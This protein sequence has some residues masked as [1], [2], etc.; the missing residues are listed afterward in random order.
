MDNKDFEEVEDIFG[1][2]IE[3][4]Y[5]VPVYEVQP[6]NNEI[7]NSVN[8]QDVPADTVNDDVPV[9]ES[10]QSFEPTEHA[11]NIVEP[12]VNE[13]VQTPVFENSIVSE[14]K[15]IDEETIKTDTYDIQPEVTP[16]SVFE[17]NTEVNNYE[18]K[19]EVVPVEPEPIYE[20]ALTDTNEVN[21]GP[22]ELEPTYDEEVN[23][24]PDAIVT[25][26]NKEEEEQENVKVEDIPN[27]KLSDN[28]SLKFV[29]IIGV[30]I[31]IAIML[32]PLLNK[33]SI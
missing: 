6:N 32:L 31:L 18:V 28:K 25:L 10:V 13:E 20:D 12:V 24:H 22:V 26:N 14:P 23:E 17:E 7:D 8:V 15:S 33:F 27:I 5:D 29:I 1:E 21:Y 4:N 3:E 9:Y 16:E 19:P 2:D 30:I 11:E